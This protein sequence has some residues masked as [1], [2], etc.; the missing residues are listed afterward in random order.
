[1]HVQKEPRM[2]RQNERTDGG[3]EWEVRADGRFFACLLM[4]P[5]GATSC[6]KEYASKQGLEMHR[7]R[8][9]VQEPS[10][11]SRRTVRL[12]IFRGRRA[13]SQVVEGEPQRDVCRELLS[14]CKGK[15][16][17]MWIS[18]RVEWRPSSKTSHVLPY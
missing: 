11:P 16:G 8:M 14:Q 3:P 5:P 13:G 4:H 17:N 12:E 18:F 2:D 7:R 9:A 1:M 6:E 15:A 10:L